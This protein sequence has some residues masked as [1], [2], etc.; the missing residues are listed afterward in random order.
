M[1]K[2]PQARAG[3]THVCTV[4]P[5]FVSPIMP[6]PMID[7][8]VGKK[9]AARAL[10]DTTMSGPPPPVGGPPIPHNFPIGSFTVY[11]NKKQALRIGDVCMFGGPINL[12]EFTVITG[13]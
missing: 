2:G 9:P 13:G 6:I 5:G 12:G 8:F 4:P 1:P 7:V 11:I 10:H 3:D